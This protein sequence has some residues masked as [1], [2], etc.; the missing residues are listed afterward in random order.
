MG[1]ALS[2]RA[3]SPSSDP[4]RLA[5]TGVEADR[6]KGAHVVTGVADYLHAGCG[7]ICNLLNTIHSVETA[8]SLSTNSSA[9]MSRRLL[10]E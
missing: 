5:P 6:A 4:T 2:D 8:E 10:L 3:T 9:S 7:A 1:V